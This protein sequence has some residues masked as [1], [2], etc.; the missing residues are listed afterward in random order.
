M[1]ND[2]PDEGHCECQS[3]CVS[4]INDPKRNKWAFRDQR[5]WRSMPSH[6]TA[7]TLMSVLLMLHISQQLTVSHSR[8]HATSDA[9]SPKLESVNIV[10]FLKAQSNFCRAQTSC[11]LPAYCWPLGWQKVVNLCWQRSSTNNPPMLLYIIRVGYRHHS[12]R[13]LWRH[14]VPLSKATGI[15][16]ISFRE[17]AVSF[18]TT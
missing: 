3:Y 10:L 6:H 11:S 14:W 5:P 9:I 1:T 4:F 16:V 7:K 13:D 15:S 2:K 12:P 8:A 17:R 18:G